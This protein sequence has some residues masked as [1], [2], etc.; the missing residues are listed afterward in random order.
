[1]ADV[2][3]RKKRS[4]VMSRIRSSGNL[5]TELRLIALMRVHGITGWRRNRRLPGKPDFVF[6]KQRVAVF[7]DGC[8]WHG[9]PAHYTEPV[10]SA[11]FWRAKISGNKRRDRRVVRELRNLGWTVL[12]LWEHDLKRRRLARAVSRLCATLGLPPPP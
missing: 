12:R 9:C 2:F 3:T 7:I 10:G 6:P 1:M 11:E 8:F 4:A 5:S